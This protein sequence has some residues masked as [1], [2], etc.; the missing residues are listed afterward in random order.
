MVCK[1]SF[2]GRRA[3]ALVIYGAK[4]FKLSPLIAPGP[5]CWRLL[6]R[7]NLD[8]RLAHCL[9]PACVLANRNQLGNLCAAHTRPLPVA[10]GRTRAR[11]T[12]SSCIDKPI[13]LYGR[14]HSKVGQRV[15]RELAW[16]VSPIVGYPACL[17][18]ACVQQKQQQQ[19]QR[20]NE[21][22]I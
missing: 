11:L 14:I 18:C 5:P 9:A 13:K 10:V 12:N 20:D 3:C 16:S 4:N 7:P 19:Q 1:R 17:K 8:R 2:S 6:A 22:S 15:E 21:E